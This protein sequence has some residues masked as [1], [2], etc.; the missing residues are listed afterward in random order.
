M[1]HGKLH[2]GGSFLV[3]FFVHSGE[4]IDGVGGQE[5]DW[6]GGFELFGEESLDASSVGWHDQS[7]L[8]ST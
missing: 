8:V 3:W 6:D 2:P 7:M 5:A 1:L 4:N